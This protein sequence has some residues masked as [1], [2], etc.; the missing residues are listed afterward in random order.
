MHFSQEVS[1]A[2]SIDEHLDI[3]NHQRCWGNC[4]YGNIAAFDGPGL[5]PDLLR[6]VHGPSRVGPPAKGGVVHH[7]VQAHQN[8][9]LPLV[10]G[11]WYN[12]SWYRRKK[13]MN[14]NY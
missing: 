12:F 5:A 2:I 4:P 8:L 10:R 1:P 6:S 13:E 7:G 9:T 3:S 14:H 11:L